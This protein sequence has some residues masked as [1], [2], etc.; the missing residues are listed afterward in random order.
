MATTVKDVA[1]LEVGDEDFRRL[2]H[3]QRA[4]RRL[5]KDYLTLAALSVIVFLILMAVTAPITTQFLDIDP[6]SEN[7]QKTYA[8]PDAENWLGTDDKGS[9]STP[10]LL[11]TNFAL[12]S[13]YCSF[14][15]TYNWFSFWHFNRVLWWYCR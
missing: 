1:I 4:V 9:F 6:F 10:N 2:T 12:S 14:S 13:V 5:R 3:M 11:R 8:G 7:L 15:V